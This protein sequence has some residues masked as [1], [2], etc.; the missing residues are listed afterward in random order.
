MTDASD[1]NGL[2]NTVPGVTSGN[3]L[4]FLVNF[5]TI[6]RTMME[7]YASDV[8][9][10]N[11]CSHSVISSVHTAQTLGIMVWGAIGYNVRSR[12]VHIT[13]NLK[14]GRY[15]REVVEG[16][17]LPLLRHIPGALFQQNN[18]RAHV[19]ENA[20]VFFSAEQVALLPWLIYSPDMS[21]ISLVSDL[22]VQ[23][24]G[25]TIRMNFG[26]KSK[27]TGIPFPRITYRACMVQSH[28]CTGS[29]RSAWWTHKVL[30]SDVPFV[31][32][33]CK[34]DRLFV[35]LSEIYGINFINF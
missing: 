9:E 24:V 18:A 6:Y 13:G 17:V 31:F 32:F 22:L 16:E 23:L 30:I 3:K 29:H 26:F 28:D 27:P 8:T 14:S 35:L 7:E 19:S 11:V 2:S 5:A 33:F 20:K 15:I 34:F 10:R 21:G 25:I 4:R 1:F 12:L